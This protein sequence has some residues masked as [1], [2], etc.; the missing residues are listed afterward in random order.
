MTL[1]Q[2][3]RDLPRPKDAN[4]DTSPHNFDH[5]WMTAAEVATLA[6]TD[7]TP[8]AEYVAPP[9]VVRRIAR[10]HLVDHV[11]GEAPAWAGDSIQNAELSLRVE[12]VEGARAHI[13]LSG[14]ARLAQPGSDGVNPF[15]GFKVDMDRGVD[16]QFVGFLV[17]DS[18][19]GVF[20]QFDVVATGSRWGAT[21]YNFR[22]EDLGP[23]PIGFAFE[24]LPPTPANLTPPKFVLW[25]Y[26]RGS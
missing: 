7:F 16:V 25:D 5:V 19:D 15:T 12:T 2:T 17:Y 6:P 22:A 21:M 1:R 11:R 4:A 3:I 24:L 26:F 23:A 14:H 18:A 13:R 10:F 9:E 20:T 8:G